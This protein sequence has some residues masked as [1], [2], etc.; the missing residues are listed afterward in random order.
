MD[1]QAAK[2]GRVEHRGGQDQ[3]IGGDDGDIQVQ[4]REG[5]VRVGVGAQAGRSANRDAQVVRRHVHGAAAHG[6]PATGRAGRLAVN[7]RDLVPGGVQGAQ[8]RYGEIGA[9]H[10]GDAHDRGGSGSGG[11]GKRRR[12]DL[13]SDFWRISLAR[14]RMI[15]LRFRL[16][17]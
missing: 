2:P 13:P 10:E 17:R 1:I 3:P 15:M 14:R 4:G 12:H 11:D 8:R 5:G 7:R 9:A 6:L 16:D